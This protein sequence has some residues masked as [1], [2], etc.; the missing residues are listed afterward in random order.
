MYDTSMIPSSLYG[1]TPGQQCISAVLKK[2]LT[3]DYVC[4]TKT[5][6]AFIENDAVGAY[7][8]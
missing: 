2:V 3:H 6:V 4:N 7:D 8:R 5:T 1:S